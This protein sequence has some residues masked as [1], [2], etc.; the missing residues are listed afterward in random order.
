MKENIMNGALIDPRT[1]K[2]KEKDYL[3]E[4]IA[5]SGVAVE[6]FKNEKI[7]KLPATEYDQWYTN[8]CVPHGYWTALEYEGILPENFTPSQLR[9]YRKRANYPS[10]GS[11]ADDMFKKIKNGQSMDFPTPAYFTESQANE[12]PYVEGSQFI[13]PFDW[14]TYRTDKYQQIP[15][16]VAQ[17]KA[18]PIF[19]FGT[20][21]EWSKEYVEATDQNVTLQNAPVRH[22]VC[23]VPKG[24]FTENGKQWLAVHDSAKFG[25]RHLRYISLDFLLK[26]TY[27]ANKII[28]SGEL[29]VQ[30][31]II[32]K[33]PNV[34]CQFGNRS[35][36][37]RVLQRFLADKGKLK[38][39]YVT[40][41]YGAL[42]AKAVLWWQL[43]NWQK[44]TSTIPELLD[45]AGKHWGKQSIDIINQ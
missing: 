32:D 16:D 14:F 4:E 34:A 8:S 43:E 30:N 24:D 2:Q 39:E 29:P 25:G 11:Y 13:K 37:V 28:A 35:E 23:L 15:E 26:R 9:S 17:G 38:P 10:A 1:D 41:Y 44:F 3:V 33:V 18:I 36:D 20:E 31:V 22:C 21:E 45:L 19:I 42:T 12:M 6:T 7:L 40:G 27:S 5:S